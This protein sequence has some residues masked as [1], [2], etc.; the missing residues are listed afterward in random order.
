MA[1]TNA[2]QKRERR[3][4]VVRCSPLNYTG[5]LCRNGRQLPIFI[6]N[7]AEDR[8]FKPDAALYYREKLLAAGCP[9]Y[10][11]INQGIHATAEIPALLDETRVLKSPVW[12]TVLHWL[13]HWLNNA[14][15]V[16][17]TRPSMQMRRHSLLEPQPAYVELPRVT[18]S[19][20]ELEGRGAGETFGQLKRGPLRPSSQS[21]PLFF[22]ETI[23]YAHENASG[24]V[25]YTHLTLPTKA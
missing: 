25:S 17:Q 4:G 11:M 10:A 15:M 1:G 6:S 9:V 12:S 3:L 19:R 16:T 14:K 24:S 2:T 23:R 8:L 5:A 22:S 18:Y 7:N 13:E 21:S 20:F